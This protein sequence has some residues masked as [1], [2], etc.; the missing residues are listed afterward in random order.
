MCKKHGNS[1]EMAV[2]TPFLV[3]TG[4][5]FASPRMPNVDGFDELRVNIPVFHTAR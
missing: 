1:E 4:T 5:L 3:P 2:F